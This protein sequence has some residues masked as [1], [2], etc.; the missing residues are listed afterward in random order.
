MFDRL[1]EEVITLILNYLENNRNISSFTKLSY[2][3]MDVNYILSLKNVNKSFKRFIEKQVDTWDECKTSSLSKPFIIS[4]TRSTQ[5]DNLCLKKTPIRVFRWLFDNN[6]HLS[7]KNIQK[8]I[9]KDR[10]DVFLLGFHYQEFLKT[11]FNRFQLCSSNDI[12][13]LSENTNPMVTAV[14]H[15]R[16]NIVKLL[17]ETSTNGNVYLDQITGIFEESIKFIKKGTLNYLLINHHDKLKDVINKKFNT[18][19][20]RFDNIEDILFYIIINKKAD[21]NREILKSI[22]SKNYIQLFEYCHKNFFSKTRNNSDLLLKC[23]ESN[24]FVIFDYLMVNGSYIHPSEF[25]EIFLS[26]K[27]HHTIFLNMI[28]DKY[29]DLIP[30]KRNIITVAIKNKV[31]ER[32]IE[33]LIKKSYQ[34][35]EKDIIMVLENKNILLARTMINSYSV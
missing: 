29:L 15:D 26:K 2:T 22:I 30:I 25:S 10:I 19:I 20:L 13:G 8:L 17:L 14:R 24:S 18:I 9:I 6:I 23:L 12:F 16:V 11:I 7:T 1:P 27:K 31:D 34:Y 21:V 5:V 4:E 33:H 3:R 28:L 35:D 32:R